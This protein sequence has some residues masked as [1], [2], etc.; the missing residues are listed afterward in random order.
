VRVLFLYNEV[1]SLGIQYLSA[2]LRRAGHTTGLVFDPR[3]FDFFRHEY[4][5][6]LLARLCSFEAQ[7]LERVEEFRPDVVAFSM[8]TANADWCM[9]YAREIGRRW[10]GVV[11]VA[12][13]YHATASSRA[14]LETGTIDWI[15]R[16]EAEESLVELV[17][18]LAAG[19]VDS[20]IPN[21]AWMDRSAP[22]DPV[23]RENPLRPYESDLDRYGRPD[24][25]LFHQVGA[26][27][28]T[29]H[30]VEWRRGCPWGCTFCGNNYYRR[31]YYPDRKDWM[32]TKEFVR[33]QSVDFA[34]AELRDIKARYNPRILRVNDDDICCDEPWLKELAEKM[35]DAERIPFKCFA[36]PNNINERTIRYLKQIGCAQIQMG[37]QSLNA[38][39]R[40][41][42]GR[43]NSEAQIARAIDLAREH[44]IGLF[45]DQ[46]F[47]LPGETEEDCRVMERFYRQHPPDVVSVY[48]LDIWAGADILQQAVNAGTLSQEQADH[49]SR[50]AESGDIATVRRYHN[51]FAKPYAARLEVR[52]YFHPRLANFLNDTGLWRIPSWLGWFRAARV[53][54]AFTRAWNLRRWPAPHQGYDM[55]WARFPRFFLR[56]MG[57]RVASAVTGRTL[58]PLSE[59]PPLGEPHERR[60]PRDRARETAATATTAVSSVSSAA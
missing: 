48:W 9:R 57:M 45:V 36:I 14:V 18:N 39:T 49:I 33:S 23:Y 3:L 17:D 55:S 60:V 43:P 30:M 56:F 19:A 51:A 16:G 10:P 21:L 11:R 47:G 42:I 44:G 59:L 1:E 4:N 58:L 24:K 38:E 5:S 15:V 27:F 29:G 52:N 28:T 12:G 31:Q 35:T 7:A 8:L 13:G 37:V 20:G 40:R 34:L 26:P 41:L 53:W 6:R 2:A 50:V 25:D 46:I 32:Y 22:G 54:Y